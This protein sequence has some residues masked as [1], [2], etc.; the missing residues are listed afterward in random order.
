[1]KDEKAISWRE[2][3]PQFPLD[4]ENKLM[5]G[6]WKMWVKMIFILCFYLEEEEN[7]CEREAIVV[8]CEKMLLMKKKKCKQKSME[9]NCV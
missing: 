3:F 1:M 8:I 7:E 6:S 2:G 9:R 4:K 5:E